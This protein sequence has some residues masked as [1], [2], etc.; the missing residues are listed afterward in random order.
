M[1]I[2]CHKEPSMTRLMYGIIVQ[3]ALWDQNKQ[4][5][6]RKLKWLKNAKERRVKQIP[7]GYI[8]P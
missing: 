6:W 3:V 4:R 1:G 7:D 2:P 5:C 8:T